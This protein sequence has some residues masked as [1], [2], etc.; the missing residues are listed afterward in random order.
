[1]WRDGVHDRGTLWDSET[2][3]ANGPDVAFCLESGGVV[4]KVS[5]RI[6]NGV[7]VQQLPGREN[8]G[9][10]VRRVSVDISCTLTFSLTHIQLLCF[11]SIAHTIY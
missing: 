1:M 4:P 11:L 2:V 7:D 3:G 5:P 6:D 8:E 10:M 9:A